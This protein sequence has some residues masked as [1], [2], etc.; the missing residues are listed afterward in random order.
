MRVK[1]CD[2]GV[3]TVQKEDS[4]LM[5]PVEQHV[6][7]VPTI[8]FVT[9]LREAHLIHFHLFVVTQSKKDWRFE[10][11]C[12]TAILLELSGPALETLRLFRLLLLNSQRSLVDKRN[13]TKRLLCEVLL[14]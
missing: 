1:H 4:L 2:R 12:R 3:P 10:S 6:H 5:C 11:T 9:Q 8:R 13:W 7:F 14:R